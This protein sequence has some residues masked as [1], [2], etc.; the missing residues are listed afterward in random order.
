[1][2]LLTTLVGAVA[3]IHYVVIPKEEH[4]LEQTFGARYLDYKTSV[5]RWL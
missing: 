1:V 2:W 5:R 3:L 4:Y